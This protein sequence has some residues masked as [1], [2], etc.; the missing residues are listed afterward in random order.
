MKIVGVIAIVVILGISLFNAL[1]MLISPSKWF[2]LPGWISARGYFSR[3]RNERGWGAVPVR[4]AGLG[5]SALI[6]YMIFSALFA[7]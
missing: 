5:I 6:G 1:F 7:R 3:E 4:L 2:D